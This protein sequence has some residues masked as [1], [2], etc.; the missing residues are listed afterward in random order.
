[1]QPIA[2]VIALLSGVFFGAAFADDDDEMKF[3][4]CPAAVRKTLQ[5]EA[6]NAKIETV[7]T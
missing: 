5:A 3:V 1:M 6:K 2:F 4:D 7:T